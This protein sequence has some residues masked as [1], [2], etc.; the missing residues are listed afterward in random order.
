MSSS[1][2]TQSNSAGR[3]TGMVH[4]MTKFTR[5]GTHWR[6]LVYAIEPSVCGGDAALCQITLTTCCH[7]YYYKNSAVAE[8]GDRG[9]NR[10]GLKRGGAA[11]PLL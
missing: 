4:M 7:D 8:M 3:R 6:H 5:G 2:Y 10:H 9:H 11:V 1:Q